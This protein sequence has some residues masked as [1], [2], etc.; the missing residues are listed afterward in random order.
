MR[1]QCWMVAYRRSGGT[2]H[3][4]VRTAV[5]QQEYLTKLTEL[6]AAG[7]RGDAMVL[8]MT[9]V[10][11]PQGVIAGMRQAPM[12][13]GLEAL[14]HTLVYDTTVM[15]DSTLATSLVSSVK[16]PTLVL[17]GSNSGAWADDAAQ[18]LTATLPASQHRILDGQSHAVAWDARAPALKEY[19]NS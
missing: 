7:R 19:F 13:P 18:A 3:W 6:L 17:T 11:L 14:T 8:F 10:G 15:G 12:W 9:T 1:A 2:R 5:L 16:V 4:D